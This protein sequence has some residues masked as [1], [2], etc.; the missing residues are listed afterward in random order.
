MTRSI[1]DWYKT[2]PRWVRKVNFVL[3]CTF[4]FLFVIT[5]KQSTPEFEA[6]IW[7]YRHG[8][9]IAVNGVIFPV[10][11]WYAPINIKDEFTVSYA[12]GPFRKA[13]D[14]PYT[15]FQI[16]GWRDEKNAGTPRELVEKEIR[17][18]EKSGYHG[19]RT[20][21]LKIRFESLEC[22]EEQDHRLPGLPNLNCYGEGP[23]YHVYFEGDED[24]LERLNR[25]LADAR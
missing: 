11:Y 9:H 8:D 13:D 20:F 10:Y 17:A 23:I 18:Y 3:L 24:A 7:H 6:I 12:P 15:A 1:R 4:A 19:V 21:Q 5:I 2:Q 22:M 14:G 16:E 25:T